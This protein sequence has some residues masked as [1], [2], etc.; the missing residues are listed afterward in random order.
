[1]GLYGKNNETDIDLKEEYGKK[2]NGLLAFL[3]VAYTQ[4]YDSEI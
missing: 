1:M 2:Y 4:K 3:N